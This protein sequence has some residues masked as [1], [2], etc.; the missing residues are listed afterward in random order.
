[1]SD[2][3]E[4]LDIYDEN[5]CRIGARPRDEVH[6]R[7]YWH[8]TFHCWLYRDTEA[9]RRLLL[10]QL[11]QHTKDTFPGCYDITAAGHLSQGETVSDAV[12]ELE[13]ELGVTASYE[14]LK[15]LMTTREEIHGELFGVPFIDR[16]VSSVFGLHSNLTL[17]QYRLQTEEVAGLYE[18]DVN[19]M[20]AL[21]QGN[22][23]EITAAGISSDAAAGSRLHER[24]VRSS[25]FVDRELSYYIDICRKIQDQ[26]PGIP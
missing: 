26:P 19:D 17:E 15:L 5:D 11:R 21:F 3:K 16:E 12:R 24:P 2:K 20:L 7:G 6:A 18:A 25:D 23:P 22:L 4:F 8:H 1:M 13:E 10:F 9:G 14:Q